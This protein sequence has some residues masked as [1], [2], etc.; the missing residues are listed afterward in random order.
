MKAIFCQSAFELCL[1]K[2]RMRFDLHHLGLDLHSANRLFQKLLREI[3]EADGL[4]FAL[5]IG[6][7]DVFCSM[8]TVYNGNH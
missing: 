4:H 3:G 6:F 5:F 2:V 1:R 7:L 8:D